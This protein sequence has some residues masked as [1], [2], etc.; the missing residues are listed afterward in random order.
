ME[1]SDFLILERKTWG[2]DVLNASKVAKVMMNKI[3]KGDLSLYS[4][5]NT[6]TVPLPFGDL[7]IKL[8]AFN[9]YKR[10]DLKGAAGYFID[11]N[12]KNAIIEIFIFEILG[13]F[14]NYRGLNLESLN[15][16]LYNFIKSNFTTEILETLAHELEHA[17]ESDRGIYAFS[18]DEP[19][20]KLGSKDYYNEIR[21]VNAR[22]I[23]RLTQTNM[24]WT[25]DLK[26]GTWLY[27]HPDK[28]TV[29]RAET[30][31]IVAKFK[32]FHM[33]SNK[34]K[35]RFIKSI[36][37]TLQYLWDHYN[38]QASKNVAQRFITNRDIAKLVNKD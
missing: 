22:I 13:N 11:N 31:A 37:T 36:Y 33:L 18:I 12:G 32:D 25:R 20:T 21:E 38:I 2:R 27:K 1:F 17:F 6:L 7:I 19:Q 26:D 5:N 24:R 30:Q 3:L 14:K 35:Q 29:T 9:N 8:K 23:E 10:E 15:N 28:D 16:I 4:H 34:N